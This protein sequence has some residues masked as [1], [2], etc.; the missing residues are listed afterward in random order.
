V[1]LRTYADPEWRDRTFLDLIDHL[2]R[3]ENL[4][5]SRPGLETF[6]RRGGR[7]VVVF[8]GL[9]EVFDP[10]LREQITR[11]IEAFAARYRR[12]RV[13]VTSRAI[14]YR[15]TILDAAGFTHHMLQDLDPDQVRRFATAW[16]R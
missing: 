7:A 6:L 12:A 4:G 9:D 5:L 13:I 8:D 16:Y 15:R 1:E 2:H 3:V 10:R 11:Q 14:G